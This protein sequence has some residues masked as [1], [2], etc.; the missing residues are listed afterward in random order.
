LKNT[1][2]FR[3][4]QAEG[5]SPSDG[6]TRVRRTAA[7]HVER[8][9]NQTQWFSRGR[10][11]KAT[12]L[13]AL[14]YHWITPDLSIQVCSMVLTKEALFIAGLPDVIDEVEL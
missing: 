3:I 7:E 12:Q 1:L 10:L 6:P 8:E 9:W 5:I 13:T 4:E 14:N 2:I 11:Y